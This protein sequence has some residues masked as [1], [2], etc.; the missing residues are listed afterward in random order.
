[1]QRHRA[2]RFRFDYIPWQKAL[3]VLLK[4]PV[5]II[6]SIVLLTL[7][8]S[9]FLT[10]P[11]NYR[12]Q[13]KV[14][15][16]AGKNDIAVV[17][18]VTG[19]EGDSLAQQLRRRMDRAATVEDFVA[20]AG[21]ISGKLSGQKAQALLI[22]LYRRWVKVD[23][24]SALTSARSL[25]Q[26]NSK[27]LENAVVAAGTAS[28]PVTY[29][30]ITGQ[31]FDD[32]Q[33]AGLVNALYYGVG[34]SLPAM[35]LTFIDLLP[36]GEQ[37]NSITTVLVRQ[38]AARDLQ[39]ALSWMNSRQLSGQM[40][41]LK[42]SLLA[43]DT[44]QDV[45]SSG[46]LIREMK[47]GR[48]KDRLA[49]EYADQLAKTDVQAA[50]NWARSLNDPESYRIALSAVFEAWVKQEPD[51]KKILRELLAESDSEMRDQLI[52]EVA[53]DI[54]SS[55]PQDLAEVFD[56]VPESAQA[57]V[58]EKIVRFWQVRSPEETRG[59]VSSLDP[60]P[61][62]D[63]AAG[64][65]ADQYISQDKTDEALALIGEVSNSASRYD[66]SRKL[67]ARLGQSNP[68]LADEVISNA[69]FLSEEE[70][71]SLRDSINNT[72]N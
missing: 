39:S 10:P 53:L 64:V 52:N 41:Q 19:Q 37:K 43:S 45:S 6:V 56:Q 12:P 34:G 40:E 16:T 38:W 42:Q 66:L 14:A 58:A 46:D 20:L 13:P 21:E 28:F 15:T 18:E 51:K 22:E 3:A 4:T 30:W 57:Q 44:A 1:M 36:D 49:R 62:R 17:E 59:W 9:L 35:V 61:V 2:K 29:Q 54:A 65:L 47:A 69:G 55:N 11:G 63:R 71:A 48:E 5:I 50:T 68:A 60:G 25:S 67:V 8:M 72:N 32:Q 24:N 7:L 26:D 27:L 33:R 31:P 70:K 23:V